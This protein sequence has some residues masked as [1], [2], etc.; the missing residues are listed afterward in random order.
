MVINYFLKVT[1]PT[2]HLSLKT[3][4]MSAV[5]LFQESTNNTLYC[6][7]KVCYELYSN[8]LCN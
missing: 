4:F 6:L 2:L 7:I 3:I 5:N 8:T 1:Y